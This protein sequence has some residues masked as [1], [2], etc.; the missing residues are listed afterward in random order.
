[1]TEWTFEPWAVLPL[2]ISA[3]LFAA[4]FGRLYARSEHGSG[5]LKRRAVLF[6]SGW[7]V[8]AVAV[9]SPIHHA[10]EH[11]FTF[12]MIEHELLMLAA[13]PLLVASEPLAVML[14]A[15][16]AGGRRVLG[17]ATKSALIAR[18]WRTL[19][20][21]LIATAVQGAALWLWHAPALFDLALEH[22][23]WHIAQHLSLLV[24]ALFFWSAMFH[25][26]NS[27]GVAAGCLFVTSLIGGALGAFM[28]VSVSPWYGPYAALG[29]TPIGL[30]P[31]EDQQLAG[32]IMWIPGG[33][34]HA[35]FAL[36][37]VGSLLRDKR[38]AGHA[39]P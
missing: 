25:R 6:A 34:F 14:W 37:F 22:E 31:A 28:A 39:H 13:A 24:S 38:E 19:T 27:P 26:R 32:L 35:V 12:H 15:F 29:M 18:P 4:G 30:T 9:V 11:A 1:M 33:L 23:G 5:A 10:G 36:V 8:L 3:G 2:A 17:G 21:P 20:D 7:L 16:P